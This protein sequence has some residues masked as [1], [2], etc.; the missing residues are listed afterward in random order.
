MR[1]ALG[2]MVSVVLVASA[3]LAQISPF[4]GSQFV[5][6]ESDRLEMSKAVSSLLNDGTPEEGAMVEWSNEETG[7][8]GT[9]SI[10]RVTTDPVLC[11]NVI[12]K[13][14]LRRPA[15]DRLF[16]VRSCRLKTGEWK[17]VAP[18]SRL[19]SGEIIR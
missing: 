8:S 2:L 5:L 3:A 11:V 1:L 7:S 6:V 10:A 14:H 13:I 16:D 9:V 15:D 17:I 12:H 4:R 18:G 19:P